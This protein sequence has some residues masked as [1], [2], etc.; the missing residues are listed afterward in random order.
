M[1]LRWVK[2]VRGSRKFALRLPASNYPPCRQGEGRR[3]GFLSG[4]QFGKLRRTRLSESSVGPGGPDPPRQAGNRVPRF[5]RFS[6]SGAFLLQEVDPPS[7]VF[8]L[9]DSC[10]RSQGNTAWRHSFTVTE[11][12]GGNRTGLKPNTKCPA[13]LFRDQRSSLEFFITTDGCVRSQRE[14]FCAFYS[15]WHALG[16]APL[17][18]RRRAALHHLQLL[19][20]AGGWPGS[21]GQAGN[22]VPRFSR[23]S[24]SGAFLL[25]EIDPP[26]GVFI[27]TDP[28]N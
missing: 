14:T 11:E 26:S 6:R 10:N 13:F 28:C 3:G 17:L 16:L 25:Q 18:R 12:L 9:T 24:R 7:E 22:R 4:T 5:S 2:R 8:I 20:T 1:D 23:F 27:I 21:L 19:S 15:P